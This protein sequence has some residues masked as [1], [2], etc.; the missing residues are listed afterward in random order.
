MPQA[1]FL[2]L[3]K[4]L[5]QYFGSEKN[6]EKI[7][8]FIDKAVNENPWF[9]DSLVRTAM[10]AIQKQFF[11]SVAW[12]DFFIRYPKKAKKKLK[13]GLILAGNLP[14]IGLHDLLMVLASG[15]V[16]QMKLSSQDK[17]LM[18]LYVGAMKE[19][20][21]LIPVH[22]IDRLQGMDAVIATGSDFSGGYFSHYFSTI[23]HIIRKNRSSMAV[24]RGD[25]TEMEFQGLAKDIFTYYGLGCR[26][27]ST[28][29][30]PKNYDLIPLFDVLS[31]EGFVLNHSKYSN[32]LQYYRT[33]Y[34]LNQIPHFDLGNII[35]SENE[36][37][38]SPVGVLYLHHYDNET[39]LLK[40]ISERE[41]KIQCKVGIN[42]DFGQS[43]QPAL[44]D[45]ADGINTYDFLV[46]L[47]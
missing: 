9:T 2:E 21:P 10:N 19:F 16:A 7:E 47:T 29:A 28:L 4:F 30:I 40:W 31:Q 23:P 42:I 32:N 8:L 20:D 37:L 5:D 14:A 34:L 39:S 43:Q 46:N 26:N 22:F 36:D 38:V 24:L 13:I 33:L 1:Q 17:S 6:K 41:E 11:S 15:Q 25:E 45:F 27:V 44:D 18:Q 35:V 3:I 12:E